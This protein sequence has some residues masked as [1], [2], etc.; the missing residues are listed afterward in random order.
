MGG[1]GLSESYWNN[2]DVP[3]GQS[4]A[5]AMYGDPEAQFQFRYTM[6]STLTGKYY[7]VLYADGLGKI[8]EVNEDN[9][10]FFVSRRDGKP[11]EYKNGIL[12]NPEARKMK[13][14]SH[15]SPAKYANTETQTLVKAPNLNTYSP[16][17]I[18]KKLEHEKKNWWFA[19]ESKSIRSIKIFTAKTLC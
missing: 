13:V 6:P 3:S 11:F 15:K 4:V 16:L 12:L 2:Y 10:F 5:A 18:Y 8:A 7:L 9:N 19:T 1:L 14:K 17:E